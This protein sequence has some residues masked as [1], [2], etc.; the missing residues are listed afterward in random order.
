[1]RRRQAAGRGFSLIEL[2]VVIAIIGAVL[3]VLLPA[4]Q[5]SREAARRVQCTNNLKQISLALLN[6]VD[7]HIQFPPGYSSLWTLDG[8]DADTAEDDLGPGWAW[9]SMILPMMEQTQIANAINFSQP[10][11]VDNQTVQAPR[12]RTLL[13]PS[14]YD[15]S[16][17]R[18]APPIWPWRGPSGNAEPQAPVRDP[19]NTRTLG[20]LARSNYVGVYGTGSIGAGPGRG[21]GMFFRNSQ[22]GFADLVDGASQTLAVGERSHNLSYVT[23]TG[24]ALGGWLFKTSSFEGGRDRFAPEPVEA[25]GMVLGAVGLEDGP[26]TPNHPRAHVEDYWSR[27]PGGACFAYADGSVHFV[28]SRIAPAVYRAL[29][30]RAGGEVISAAA[31]RGDPGSPP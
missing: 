20:T 9:C 2:L 13:C 31:Y 7:S 27:H 14:D 4:V 16:M 10:I 26:R 11:L 21:N 24:R 25:F 3:A 17:A 19:N 30:T 1:M 6:Y 15:K 8:G 12:I 23:W 22:V 18:A 5:S 28:K 29:A